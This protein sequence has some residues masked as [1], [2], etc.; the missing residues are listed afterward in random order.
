M[1]VNEEDEDNDEQDCKGNNRR[2]RVIFNGEKGDTDVKTLKI[3]EIT[4][5]VGIRRILEVISSKQVPMIGY[6]MMNDIL[7]LYHW[8]I[9]KLPETCA[10]FIRQ[11]HREFPILIDV[12]V[13]NENNDGQ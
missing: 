6:E 3:N 12:R 10:E 9:D 8:C 4:K 1:I 7:F 11:C 2:L 13:S 5:L